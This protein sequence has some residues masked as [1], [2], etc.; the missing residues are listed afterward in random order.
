[1]LEDDA[2]AVK[3]LCGSDYSIAEKKGYAEPLLEGFKKGFLLVLSLCRFCE[4]FYFD[5]AGFILR[6]SGNWASVF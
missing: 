5:S 2:I 1:M 6:R 4:F 3:I